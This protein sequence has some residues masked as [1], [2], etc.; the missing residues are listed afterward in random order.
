MVGYAST[1]SGVQEGLSMSDDIPVTAPAEVMAQLV[2]EFEHGSATDFEAYAAE[3]GVTPPDDRDGW[4]VVYQWGPNGE[5][6]GLHW[7]Q[8]ADDPLTR[9]DY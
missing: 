6:Q 9:L 4:T 8:P 5:D 3:L 2:H 1:D 7:Y